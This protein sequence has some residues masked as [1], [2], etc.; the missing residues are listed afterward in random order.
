MQEQVCP[1]SAKEKLERRLKFLQQFSEANSL[2][3]SKLEESKDSLAGVPVGFQH[4]GSGKNEYFQLFRKI[5]WCPTSGCPGT[6]RYKQDRSYK[7]DHC[8]K[9]YCL[10]CR[11]PWHEGMECS[12]NQQKIAHQQKVAYQPVP[13]FKIGDKFRACRI[14]SVWKNQPNEGL[15]IGASRYLVCCDQA[16]Y[17]CGGNSQECFCG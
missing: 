8:E 7:C 6:F 15:G 11:A 2:A 3:M 10:D 16:C 9:H 12:I 4:G 1:V 17:L 5:S 13:K 14:C